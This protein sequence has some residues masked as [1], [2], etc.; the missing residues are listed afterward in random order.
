MPLFRSYPVRIPA[1]A[2]P[3]RR[4]Q[5]T[6]A[7]RAISLD[8]T[9]RISTACALLGL[10]L[11]A[12]RAPAQT[13]AWAAPSS[14]FVYDSIGRSIRP[15]TG[16]IGAALLG[17][18]VASEID[19]VSVAPNQKSAL[20]ESNGSQVWIP[21]LS[22]GSSHP[23]DAVP[24]AWQAFWAADSSQAVILSTD[25]KLVW[26]TIF[27]SGP[28]PLSNWNLETPGGP[29]A[30]RTRLR[31][32]GVVWSI[33][34]AD[35]SAN[36]VLL[37]SHTD[38]LQQIWLASS[39]LPPQSI[40]FS[41]NPVA[42]AFATGNGGVLVADAGSHRIVRIQNLDTTP[43]L[44]TVVSSEIYLNDPAAMALSADGDR[45][46]VA[47]Q[48]GL[49]IRVFDVSGGSAASGALLA[50]LTTAD[51]PVSLTM[52]APDRFLINAGRGSQSVNFLDTGVS[53]RVSFVPGAQ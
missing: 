27:S 13:S 10:V 18:S 43:V 28:V 41:G 45:L 38:N 8:R 5:R 12:G 9:R 49:A 44:T 11:C 47:D 29:D 40:P 37:V 34:A 35:S 42:A 50:E 52:F 48:S 25:S 26:L 17:P 15:V 21:D 32:P 36:R 53:P 7:A 16:L 46:F 22:A 24:L 2:L 6:R 39:T 1:A 51:P 33:L 31:R 23:L 30:V 14:G 3:V 4:A 19:W 20:A